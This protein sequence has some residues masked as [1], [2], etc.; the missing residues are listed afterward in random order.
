MRRKVS[1]ARM[2]LEAIMRRS[3]TLLL[4]SFLLAPAALAQNADT[5]LTQA[6]LTEIRQLRQELQSMAAAMQRV[7]IVMFRVQS[8]ATILGRVTSRLEDAKS[9]CSQIQSQKRSLTTQAEQMES[10]QRTSQNT[11]EAKT[12]ELRA[13][14]LRRILG[15]LSADEQQCQL[16][17]AEADTQF[18]AEQAKMNELQ[19]QLD[20]LDKVLAAVGGK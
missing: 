6:L 12:F 11:T 16:R 20:K 17:E 18:R 10:V 5:Q 1:P 4:V 15:N 2:A 7:Q 13:G 19:D 8:Q 3:R 9:R 14:E